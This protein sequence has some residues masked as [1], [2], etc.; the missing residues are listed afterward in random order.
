VQLE[1]TIGK[2]SKKDINKCLQQV[3]EAACPYKV[4]Q[5]QKKNMRRNMHKSRDMT[6]RQFVNSVTRMNNN[7]LPHLP[8]F[9]ANQKLPNYD[10]IEI[11]LHACPNSWIQEMD[12]QDFDADHH[13]LQDL[14][15]FLEH[16]ES[17]E[18]R[19]II[20]SA[21]VVFILVMTC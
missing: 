9:E 15:K 7:E 16:I 11:V 14:L 21:S 3:I 5:K 1:E 6:I 18:P 8:P 20:C 17:L 2:V 13:T 19:G 4:L 10:V 12:R